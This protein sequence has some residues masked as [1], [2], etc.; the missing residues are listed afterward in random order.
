MI[1]CK[2]PDELQKI[3]RS[4]LIVA[5]VLEAVRKMVAV[6]IRTRD[7]D[8]VAEEMI[9]KAGGRPAFKGYNGF[10]ATLCTSVNSQIVHGIP[11]D[12]RLEAGDIV[13]IDCGVCCDGYYGDSAITVPV[14]PVSERL[15]TLMR[16]TEEALYRGIEQARVGN[17]VSDISAAVQSHVEPHG[18]SLVREFVGHGI[19]RNLHEEP[20]VPNFGPPG[21]GPKLVEGI[22]LAIEPMVNTGGAAHR[23]LADGWTA[24]TADGGY[25]AH[26]E[27][28]V[29]ITT[30]GPWILSRKN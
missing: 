15:Q 2:S 8:A 23:T 21:R 30:D 5:E 4:A 22:V 9:L 1:I 3:R 27:H 11:G 16:V 24:V 10:P 28:C 17:R 6:G 29:A 12:Q 19:G 26:F 7:L 13:S 20:Q 18:F 25:S 14:G